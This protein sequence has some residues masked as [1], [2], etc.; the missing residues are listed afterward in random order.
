MPELYCNRNYFREHFK[1]NRMPCTQLFHD[2]KMT[3]EWQKCGIWGQGATVSF[4][5]YH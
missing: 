5:I 1:A 2:N 4:I 3:I